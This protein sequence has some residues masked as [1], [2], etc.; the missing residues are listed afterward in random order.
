MTA[1]QKGG[2]HP[3]DAGR[4][5]SF[6]APGRAFELG[7]ETGVIGVDFVAKIIYGSFSDT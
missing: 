3:Q 6:C 5:A 2:G 1:D 4:S 7:E